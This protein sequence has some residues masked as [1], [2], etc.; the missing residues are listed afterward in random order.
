MANDDRSQKFEAVKESAE[1]VADSVDF[2]IEAR[3]NEFI[4]RF[5]ITNQ[6]A[7]LLD[8]FTLAVCALHAI[9]IYPVTPILDGI[10]ILAAVLSLYTT[11][12]RTIRWIS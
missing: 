4:D 10:V 8:G 6:K 2:A 12:K 1:Q 3:S 11:T 9:F 5:G 7:N